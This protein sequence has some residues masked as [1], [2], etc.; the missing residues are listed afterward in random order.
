[1]CNLSLSFVIGALSLIRP[2]PLVAILL[3]IDFILV[4]LD[5]SISGYMRLYGPTTSS[6]LIKL[7]TLVDLEDENNLPTWYS[8][9]QLMLLA[10]LF[11]LHAF[12]LRKSSVSWLVWLP[13]VVFLILSI[14]EIAQVHEWVG[15]QL[16]YF[17][18]E[19][20]RANTRL[21]YSG[22]WGFAVGI[23]VLAFVIWM[24]LRLKPTFSENPRS[25]RRFVLGSVFLIGG[26]AGFDIVANFT[27]GTP[28]HRLEVLVEEGC[29][30][31]GVTI[32][33]WGAL[34]LV[35]AGGFRLTFDPAQFGRTNLK[36]TPALQPK[37]TSDA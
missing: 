4:A 11:A 26:A 5:F 20:S 16:D 8:A 19:G 29:E 6:V 35:Q 22:I 21:G 33:C 7:K 17:M 13:A 31:L 18:P 27:V 24:W 25:F 10:T 3:L 28:F 14:D 1:M 12:R 32:L 15:H 23:P 2:F 37:E 36:T 34:E 30:M 9:M